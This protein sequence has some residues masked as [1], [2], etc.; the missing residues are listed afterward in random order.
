MIQ[1]TAYTK[2]HI[3]KHGGSVAIFE[4]VLAEGEAEAGDPDLPSLWIMAAII[5]GCHWRIVFMYRDN[6]I[7]PISLHRRRRAK[8]D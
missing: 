4:Q 2:T 6:K 1:W 3:A 5:A 7:H 8:N